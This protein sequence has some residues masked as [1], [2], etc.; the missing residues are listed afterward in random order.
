MLRYLCLLVE[1]CAQP[2]PQQVPLQLQQGWVRRA[3][4]RHNAAALPRHLRRRPTLVAGMLLDRTFDR[5]V[6][7]QG[8]H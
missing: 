5:A 6:R 8:S 1:G 2:G 4:A 3:R 7:H